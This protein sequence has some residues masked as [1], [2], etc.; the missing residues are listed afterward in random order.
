MFHIV[1]LRRFSLR[2]IKTCSNCE[3][4]L[5][6]LSKCSL[7]LVLRACWCAHNFYIRRAIAALAASARNDSS[8]ITGTGGQGA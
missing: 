7:V 8:A 6:N 2:L 1:P 3:P 5:P 4:G